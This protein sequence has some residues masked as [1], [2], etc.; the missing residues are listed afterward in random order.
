MQTKPCPHNP[1]NFHYFDNDFD[2]HSD[3][4]LSQEII[5]G[6]KCLTEI[7]RFEL[8]N[9]CNSNHQSNTIL[10][11]NKNT[12]CTLDDIIITNSRE[13]FVVIDG[14]FSDGIK[15]IYNNELCNMIIA[16]PKEPSNSTNLCFAQNITSDTF[17]S[18]RKY[19]KFNIIYDV[20]GYLDENYPNL[21][22]NPIDQKITNV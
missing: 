15:R 21:Q 12:G 8:V 5:A 10:K 20:H 13:K 16:E 14:R 4:E 18:L 6:L 22:K 3:Y 19:F 9:R 1:L 17:E 11:Y 2:Y 7:Y